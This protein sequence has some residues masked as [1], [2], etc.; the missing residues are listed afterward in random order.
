M[1]QCDVMGKFKIL[2]ALLLFGATLYFLEMRAPQ[3]PACLHPNENTLYLNFRGDPLSL[4][5]RRGSDPLSPALHFM[6][7]QGLTRMT[8]NS[9][10]ELSLAKSLTISKDR[11]TYTFQLKPSYWSDQSLITSYDFERS[12]KEI[13]NHEAPSPVAHLFFVI[14]NGQAAFEGK[15]PLSEVGIYTPDS[16]TLVIEL[17]HPTSYFLNLTSFC[18]FFPVKYPSSKQK[19]PKP[20][21]SGPFCL[22]KW[23]HGDQII[24]EKNPFYWD[25][26]NVEIQGI[27]INIVGS[28]L[29]SLKMFENGEIDFLGGPFSPLPIDTISVLSKQGSVLSSPLGATT[30]LTFNIDKFPYSNKNIR[31]GISLAIGRKEIVE[32]LT[33]LH[34]IVATG[35][36]APVLKNGRNSSFF[37]DGNIP[38]AREY[39]Q[40]GLRELGISIEDFPP[41]VLSYYNED[42]YTKIAQVVQQQL[43]EA[44]GVKVHLLGHE[45]QYFLHKLKKKDFQIAEF[46]WSPQYNDPMNIFERF[47]FKTN[48]KNYSG[49]ENPNYIALLESSEE[50]ISKEERFSLLE[51]AEE[52]LVE[53]TPFTCLYHWNV[54]YLIH[55]RVQ[56]CYISP[57]GSIHWEF[58]KI[59]PK[60]CSKVVL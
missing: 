3:R 8:P 16:S 23:L 55:P 53:E 51:A 36:I 12:W 24:L 7:L 58:A 10:Y 39:F 48:S 33:Q 54:N 4:D 50:A 46:S 6:T 38:L 60:N 13:L 32:N 30:M 34:E 49:W 45:L 29:T 52:L 42:A 26:K 2:I 18:A 9:P 40:L 11:K 28:D 1:I 14:K 59:D 5:P 47:K 27:H 19:E 20:L 56:G 31:K 15:V 41:I 25:A 57:I 21:S 35:V 37:E 44:L 22:K 17:E 43:Q